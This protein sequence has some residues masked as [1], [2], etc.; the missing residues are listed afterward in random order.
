[1]VTVVLAPLA[2]TGGGDD[3]AA[4]DAHEVAV[5]AGTSP[6][7]TRALLGKLTAARPVPATTSTTTTA[8]VAAFAASSAGGA[9]A[10]GPQAVDDEPATTTTA[11]PRTTT[12]T[13]A[14]STTTTTAP[15]TTTTAA[16]K[17]TTT[18]T[19]TAPPPPPSGNTE[20]GK[21]SWYDHEAGICAHKTLPFG[22]VVTVTHRE[23]GRSVRCTV[24]DRGPFI[25]G[26]VIDLHPREFEQLAPLDHGVIPVRLSW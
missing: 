1:M 7:D 14:P 22:T 11:A 26:W 23:N 16:P 5:S 9:G 21:A 3:G 10:D 4:S 17:P 20:E 8:E 24:G 19:T 12:T 6:F 13:A 15:R 2:F 25:E 18:T